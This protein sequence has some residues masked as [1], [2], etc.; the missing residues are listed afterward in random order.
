LKIGCDKLK[1]ILLTLN[2][3]LNTHI[4]QERDTGRDREREREKERKR[5]GERN[6][7]VFLISSHRRSNRIIK[8][9]LT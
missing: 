8:K 6:N 2:Q 1:Y 5:E 4:P 7:T 9:A 3:E